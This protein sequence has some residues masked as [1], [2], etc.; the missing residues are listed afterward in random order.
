MSP[1]Y[2][3]GLQLGQPPGHGKGQGHAHHE[4]EGWLDQVVQRAALPQYM[5]P[6]ESGTLPKAALREMGRHFRQQHQAGSHQQ[7]GQT[8]ESIQ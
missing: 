4:A 7:H 1:L 5:L 8:A 2:G 6:M 3:G